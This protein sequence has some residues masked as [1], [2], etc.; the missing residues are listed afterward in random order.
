MFTN[1]LAGDE[2][3]D[4]L[5]EGDD[6]TT[7]ESQETVRTL[8]RVVGL[9]RQTTERYPS[10]ENETDCSDQ[11]EMKSLRLLTT[12][13]GSLLAAKAVILIPIIR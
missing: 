5:R 7:C 10:P 11:T 4:F 2:S 9:K 8:G 6:D 13:R 1:N 12:V 3:Q